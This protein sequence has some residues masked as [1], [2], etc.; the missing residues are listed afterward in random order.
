MNYLIILFLC[1]ASVLNLNAQLVSISKLDASGFPAMKAEFYVLDSSWKQ[2]YPSASE[3]TLT[4]N[5]TPRVI[6]SVNFPTPPLPLA[7][8]AVLT[9]DISQTKPIGP[10]GSTPIEIAQAGARAWIQDLPF[11]I[12]ECALTSFDNNSYLLQEFTT[13]PTRLSQA[14]GSLS[15][16]NGGK[17]FDVGMLLPPAGSLEVSKRGKFKRVIIV[18]TDGLPKLG[19]N[20]SVVIEE[21]KRQQCTIH[22]ITLGLS[23]PY[24]L[25]ELA[26]QTGGQWFENITTK[27]QAEIVYRKIMQKYIPVTRGEITWTSDITCEREYGI[28]TELLWQSTSS[29]IDTPSPTSAFASLT[30]HPGF[31]GFEKRPPSIKHDTTITLTVKDADFTIT[32][33]KRLAG[34]AEFSIVNTTFPFIIP[35]NT[36]KSIT[37][38]FA[39]SD[40]GLTYASFI[41]ETDRCPGSF[42]CYGGYPGKIS[43]S[44]QLKLIHPNGGEAY[45]LG[46]KEEITWSG[47][48]PYN[49]VALE[50]SIDGGISWSQITKQASGLKYSWDTIPPVPSNQCLVRVRQNPGEL[51]IDSVR[52]IAGTQSDRQAVA[53]SPNGDNI[54][55]VS[56]AA[57]VIQDMFTLT[58]TGVLYPQSYIYDIAYSPDG[59]RI[60]TSGGS[61]DALIWD[62]T[63]GSIIYSLQGHT[64]MI[65]SVAFSPDGSTV[66]TGS[67]DNTIKIWDANTSRLLR[68]LQNHTNQVR[69]VVYSPDGSRI[70]SAS[71][72]ST[73]KIWDALTGEIVMTLQGHKDKLM[74]IAFSPD[75]SRIA[76]TG[77]DR[78]V[79]IWD[80]NTGS[81]LGSFIA[82]LGYIYSI[83]YSPDGSK[84][85]TACGTMDDLGNATVKIWD[86]NSYSLLRTLVGHNYSIR[87]LA[88]S[89]DGSKIATVGGD[90][91]TKIWDVGIPLLQ[92]DISD[93]EFSIVTSKSSISLSAKPNPVEKILQ[94]QYGLVEPM[95]V[96]LELFTLTGQL[97][98]SIITNQAKDAGKYTLPSDLS[99]LGTGV[100]ILRL[101]TDKEMLTTKVVVIK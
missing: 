4:E 96:T 40:S 61:N 95:T 66:C 42:S 86:A 25:K 47:L 79:K 37:L 22:I 55:Y 73:A 69:A 36:S 62:L 60:A 93:A 31:I 54:A 100:Y 56:D 82:H 49:S 23:C 87:D 29:Y 24:I 10:E 99:G 53:F 51:P 32:D 6:T 3:L 97:A 58:R 52:T 91:T 1:L 38:R 43:A 76:T 71:F 50:Y 5:R 14:V 20:T 80:A 84:I 46:Q 59:G 64:A 19:P 57:V 34:S 7:L 67:K 13:D 81:Q 90:W 78:I 94:I 74:D 8:S 68:T 18:L 16:N 41:I 11:G 33:I 48:S 72:D 92:E 77:L 98:Q 83:S 26:T 70:A 39:P 45:Q 65:W 101:R 12:S 17:N 15:A 9:M 88:Y 28:R 35:K 44:S 63:T 27:Q 89:P 30:V 2:V 21:A 85:A 75:G